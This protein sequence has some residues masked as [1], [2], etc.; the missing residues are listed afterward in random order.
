MVYSTHG[1]VACSQPLAAQA[2]IRVLREGGNAAV[3][4][5]F[6]FFFFVIVMFVLVGEI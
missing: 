1:I 3:S 5:F 2:G 6:F 4:F